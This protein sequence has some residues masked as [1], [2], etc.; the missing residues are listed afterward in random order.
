[1]NRANDK[2]REHM[3]FYIE[4]TNIFAILCMIL[5]VLSVLFRILG[6]QGRWQDAFYVI[7]QV[8][9]IAL[10]AL[11]MILVILFFGKNKIWLSSIPVFLGVVSFVFKLFINPRFTGVFHH[12]LCVLLYSAIVLL[13]VL[14]VTGIIRTKW[15]LVI[16]FALPLLVHLFIEDLPVLIGSAAPLSMSAWMQE[17]SMLCIMSGLICFALAMKTRES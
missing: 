2:K 5:M 4:R 6:S 7:T 9:L 12:V 14:S 8:V 13:W 17:F 10:C 11:F 1:M 16:I 15:L 3:R